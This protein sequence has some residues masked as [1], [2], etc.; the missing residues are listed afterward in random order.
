MIFW[1][2]K[3]EEI[4]PFGF[5]FFKTEKKKERKK[6]KEKNVPKSFPFLSKKTI[7]NLKMKRW[8][9]DERMKIRRTRMIKNEWWIWDMNEWVRSA[10]RI[11]NEGTDW[12]TIDDW[13]E[14]ER[15]SKQ[16]NEQSVQI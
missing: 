12:W 5:V 13:T 4:K 7:T 6:I 10:D 15:M 8:N 3:K 1:K 16:M 2:L 11:M 14:S 9:R